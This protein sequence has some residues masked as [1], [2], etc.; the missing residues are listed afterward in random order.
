VLSIEALLDNLISGE[1]GRAEAAAASLIELGMSALPGLHSLLDS[2]ES[3]H[4]WWAIRTLAGMA[5]AETDWFVPFLSDPLDEIRQ[6]A[7]LALAAHP[8]PEAVP[9]LC[10]ALSD[11]DSLTASL[12][13]T[14]LAAHGSEA[15]PALLEVQ[16]EAPLSARIQAMRALSQIADPRAIPAMMSAFEEDSAILQHWA[17]TGLERLGLDTIYLKPE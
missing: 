3:D 14:A 2:P 16:K 9:A 6:C 7:A 10:Q 8:G 4:R 13:A 11:P 12:A 1:E 17:E 5:A 15:T